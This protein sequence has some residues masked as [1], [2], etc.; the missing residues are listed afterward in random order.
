M[1]TFIL[2]LGSTGMRLGEAK[3]I[4]WKDIR[5]DKKQDGIIINVDESTSKVRRG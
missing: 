5:F 1:R 4:R 3:Q 2:F